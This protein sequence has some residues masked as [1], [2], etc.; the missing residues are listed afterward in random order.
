M[1]SKEQIETRLRLGASIQPS[2][3]VLLIKSMLERLEEMS[4]KLNKVIEKQ[5][6]ISTNRRGINKDT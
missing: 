2:E 1:Y 4:N 5:N 3:V 6:E